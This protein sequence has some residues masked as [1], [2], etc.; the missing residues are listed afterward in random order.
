MPILINL[1]L[2]LFSVFTSKSAEGLP[3]T[4]TFENSGC[5]MEI[6]IEG[7]LQAVTFTDKISSERGWGKFPIKLLPLREGMD[8]VF[9]PTFYGDDKARLVYR[10]GILT[11]TSTL[12]SNFTLD[13][14]QMKVDSHLQKPEWAK[15]TR[16]GLFPF[17]LLSSKT[18][19]NC[20]L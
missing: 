16:R 7:D 20:T 5:K 3:E 8:E 9:Q 17:N 2:V 10:E 11:V 12:R 15:F 13:R 1:V 14:L 6:R 19:A 18:K 4:Q